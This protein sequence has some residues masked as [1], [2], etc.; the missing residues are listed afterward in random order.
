MNT[1]IHRRHLLLA[2][3]ALGAAPSDYAQSA[4][5]VPGPFDLKLMIL[6]RRRPGTSMV[7]HRQHIRN[8]HG[9]MVL[10]YIA[11]DPQNAPR[12]YV[13][14]AVFDGQYRSSAPGSDPFALNRDFVTQIWFPDFGAL[15]RSLQTPFY[16]QNLKGDED[17]FVDQSTVVPLTV[18]EREVVAQRAPLAGACKL[19]FC[20]QR[21]PDADPEAFRA[22]WQQGAAALQAWPV[23]AKLRR[24]VQ[25]D[26]M[27]KPGTTAPLDGIDEFWLDD[28]AA[29]R[30][31]WTQWQTWVR[32]TLVAK[33]L[34]TA[35]G[36]FGLLAT[37]AVLYAGQG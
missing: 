15:G 13:Q 20:I 16:L 3:L 10:R 21:A 11:T 27:A 19:F 12:R 32:D 7:E 5:Q 29:A 36:H 31:L 1:M 30:S 4:P 25:N 14:N 37:E 24:Y 18:R 17:N 28:E 2:S 6:G 22:A 34:A 33:G 8:V 35:S 9:E 23:A 26:A